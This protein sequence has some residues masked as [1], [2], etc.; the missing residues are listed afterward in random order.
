MNKVQFNQELRKR[1][2]VLPDLEIEK[3]LSYFNEMIDDR[4]EEGMSEEEAIANLGD[5]RFLA[6]KILEEEGN[7][8]EQIGSSGATVSNTPKSKSL[9]A[10]IGLP[11]WDLWTFIYSIL[12]FSLW[13]FLW[14]FPISLIV[15]GLVT[16]CLSLFQLPNGLQAVVLTAGVGLI[17]FG[18]GCLILPL[19]QIFHRNLLKF[20]QDQKKKGN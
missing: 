12:C 19:T 16:L 15:S 18:I 1:L 13:L 6:E 14:I 3:S 4:I 2:L 7:T 17:A 10:I 11:F 8:V 20:Y 5:I 9:L